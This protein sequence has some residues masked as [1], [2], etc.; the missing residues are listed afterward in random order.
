MASLN[1]GPKFDCTPEQ[2]AGLLRFFRTQIFAKPKEINEVDLSGK[3]AIVTGANSGVGL[4]TSRQLLA[5][6]LERL[7]LAVRNEEKGKA[8][9]SELSSGQHKATATIEVW[10][11]DLSAYDSVLAFAKRAESLERLDHVILNAGIGPPKFVLNPN[12]GH[13]ET[14]QVN[15]L[16]TA[17]L[18]L[19]LLPVIKS[20]RASQTQPSCIT[21]VSSEVA[22]WTKFREREHIPLLPTFDQPGKVDM[23][24][25]MMVS[26][27]LGQFFLVELAKRVPTSV[28]LI[29]AASPGGVHDSNFTSEQD[30]SFA[31]GMV[32]AVLRRLYNTSSV[33][34]RM[35]TD[36]AINRGKET[37]GQFLSFQ[38][39]VP[40][41]DDFPNTFGSR[42]TLLVSVLT[43]WYILSLAP[44]IYTAQGQV[45][46]QR[47]WDETMAEFSFAKAQDILRE[48][49]A[50]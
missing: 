26:K 7:I 10:K 34:A 36:A 9:A 27:L 5:L 13:E 43:L 11:L 22:G 44:V 6:G 39:M 14:I 23:L 32:K 20:K 46:S 31:G 25:R 35:I 49:V 28:A 40:Y 3:T 47:L 21:F 12:T 2:G 30:K 42:C 45:L 50:G 16:S 15:Y 33:G 38:E 48:V 29:N 24:D 1:E 19:L 8:A 4:E 41:V 37:H 18:S 17:L